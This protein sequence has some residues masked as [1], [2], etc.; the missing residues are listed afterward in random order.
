MKVACVLVTHLPMKAE[1]RRHPE[2]Q[3]KP[4]IIT[5][6][7]GSK[8]RVLD[9]SPEARSVIPG[10]PLQE[11][12]SR[13]KDVVLLQA[14]EPYYYAIFDAMV[15]S[16]EQR[17]PLVEKAELGG[18]YVGLD[19]LEAMYGSEASLITSLLQA[20][21]QAFNPRIGVATGKFPA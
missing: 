6:S 17:S 9:A 8:Q 12:I 5:E 18:A 19:G 7:S 10:M 1:L 11:A 20:I 14:D 2:L 15:R 21:P 4:V 16:L 13:C 3:G